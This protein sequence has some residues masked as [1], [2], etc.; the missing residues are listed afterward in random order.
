[1]TIS[2]LYSTVASTSTQ[3]VNLLNLAMNYDSFKGSDYIIFCDT[4]YSYYIVWGDLSSSSG[5]VTGS[6]ISYIHYYRLDSS[7][8]SG[9]YTYVYG[10]DSSFNLTLSDEY[11]T[12]S[13]LPGVGFVSLTGVQYEYYSTATDATVFTLAVL[14]VLMFL[15]FRRTF[16]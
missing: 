3:A 14:L 7:S 12:T 11:L 9:T 1:M 15:A 8:Y 6:D 16:R 10:E 2:S 4:Q 13:S 5:K